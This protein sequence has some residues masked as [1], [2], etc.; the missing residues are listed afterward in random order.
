M[1]VPRCWP[2]SWRPTAWGSGC[3]RSCAATGSRPP[4]ATA[5][6]RERAARRGRGRGGALRAAIER[7]ERARRQ[8]RWAPS[9]S[10]TREGRVE[11]MASAATHAVLPKLATREGRAAADRRR[12][13]LAPSGG[14]ATAEGFWL[15]ECAYA[16]GPRGAA[17]RARHRATPASTRARTSADRRRWRRFGCRAAPVGFTIDWPTVAAGLVAEGLSRPIPPTSST[18]ASPTTGAPLVDLRASP[19]TRRRPRARAREHARAFL[20]RS[21]RRLERIAPSAG[22][23]ACACSRSTPSCS[24]IGGAEGPIWLGEVI[25]RRRAAR[26]AAAEALRGAREHR[27]RGARRCRVE[28]GRGEGPR[29]LGLARGLRPRLGG[30]AA[31]AA[32]A[33]Q[34]RRRRA[35]SAPRAERAARELLAVQSSDWAF[36]DH[37]GQAGDYPYRRAT[38]HAEALLEAIH[39][40]RGARNRACAISPP[41]SSLAPLLEP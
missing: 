21:P 20:A 27:A 11:L 5:P 41:I 15:P 38:G 2:T 3:S 36:M 40:A 23:R 30:E 10:R 17:G 39:S 22:G 37:R 25:S 33:A 6:T 13:A 19:T 4:S 7:L 35:S 31:G 34:P 12:A 9:R 18:T 29:D 1:T 26:R 28:L 32:P 8:R 24:G 14:S 16:P